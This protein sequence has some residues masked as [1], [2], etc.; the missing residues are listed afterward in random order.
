VGSAY[1]LELRV[2]NYSGRAHGKTPSA[3]VMTLPGGRSEVG[4][5]V[6]ILQANPLG[7]PMKGQIVHIGIVGK[8][9]EGECSVQWQAGARNSVRA[10]RSHLP[11][12]SNP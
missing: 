2:V 8:S 7:S 5:S 11:Q 9:S 3:I 4:L 6:F 1:A 12:S 10:Y